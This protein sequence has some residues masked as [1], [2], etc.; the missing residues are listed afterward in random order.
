MSILIIH[1][2]IDGV[3]TSWYLIFLYSL[4]TFCS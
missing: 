1:L 4:S 2:L 3:K